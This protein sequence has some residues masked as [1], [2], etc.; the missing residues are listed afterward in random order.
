VDFSAIY[1][2]FVAHGSL[3]LRA[4]RSIIFSIPS[5]HAQLAAF[6]LVASY[7]DRIKTG[8]SGCSAD[9]IVGF[10]DSAQFL[11]PGGG[12]VIDNDYH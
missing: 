2:G 9:F 6:A 1:S 7:F 5:I 12:F 10:L 11:T 8:S 3:Y 4:D